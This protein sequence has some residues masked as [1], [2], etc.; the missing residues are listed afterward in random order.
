MF[1]NPMSNPI[2]QGTDAGALDYA[3]NRA[4]DAW[5]NDRD[6][7]RKLQQRVMRQVRLPAASSSLL[8]LDA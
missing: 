1:I 7:T 8:F 3:L 5:Y 4:L 6:W 2:L